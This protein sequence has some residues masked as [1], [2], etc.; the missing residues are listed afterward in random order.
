[1]NYKTIAALVALSPLWALPAHADTRCYSRDE[2]QAEQ[3]LRLHSE[4]MVITVTCKQSSVGRD[5]VR[6]YTGFTKHNIAQIK[7]AEQTL[8]RYY[9]TAYG[10][11]GVTK[12]DRLRTKLA[13][14]YGQEVAAMSAPAFC[15]ERR[16]KVVSMYDEPPDSLSDEGMKGYKISLSTEPVCDKSLKVARSSAVHDGNKEAETPKEVEP[17]PKNIK[18]KVSS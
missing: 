2:V 3:V 9:A 6:A 18:K 8:T 7:E 11:D 10:G 16:D 17:K 12:L 13:N 5:L 15:A 14:E 4:L 1:M